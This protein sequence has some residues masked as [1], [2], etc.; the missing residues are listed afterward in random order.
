MMLCYP[1]GSTVL[2]RVIQNFFVRSPRFEQGLLI[3]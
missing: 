3:P 2:K 1:Y